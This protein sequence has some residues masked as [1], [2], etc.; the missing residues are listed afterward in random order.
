[1]QCKYILSCLSFDPFKVTEQDVR[2]SL[3]RVELGTMFKSA[4]R[5]V[6]ENLCEN[7][8][9]KRHSR[10]L[11]K[12]T[13]APRKEV[14]CKACST[15]YCTEECMKSHMEVHKDSCTVR[16][17]LNISDVVNG[18]VVDSSL[19]KIRMCLGDL[20]EIFPD[21]SKI[22]KELCRNYASSVGKSIEE[23]S[24][25]VSLDDMKIC[26]DEIPVP[27]FL[28]EFM[29]GMYTG[30]LPISL[31]T[32]SCT[33]KSVI[34]KDAVITLSLTRVRG[35]KKHFFV[36]GFPDKEHEG[37]KGSHMASKVGSN[38]GSSN[39]RKTKKK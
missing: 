10:N 27:E 38:L 9:C 16:Q 39:K 34:K 14:Y 7:G 33:P 17:I 2:A 4:I 32:N 20:G 5:Y 11:D 3:M 8:G 22:V 21:T 37:T 13:N 15:V 29:I 31:S 30:T 6:L 35:S 24:A 25:T 28:F 1:M 26:S 12:K 18:V 23:V 36:V 19:P